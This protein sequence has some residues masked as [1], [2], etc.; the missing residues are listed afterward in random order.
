MKQRPATPCSR[1]AKLQQTNQELQEHIRHLEDMVQGLQKQL[2]A[3][4]KDSSTSSKPPSSDIVKPTKAPADPNAPK[5]SIG[6]QP[7][8]P[9]HFRAPF[10]AEEVTRTLPHRLTQCPDCG[11]LLEETDEPP[12]IVQQIDLNPVTF[13]I[14]EHQSHSGWCPHCHKRFAA[15]LPGRIEHGGLLGPQLTALVAYLKGV[16]H[17]SFST[18]RK[19]FRDVLALPI[20]RSYLAKTISKVSAAL[21]QPYEELWQLLP[22]E[23]CLNVDETGHKLN[24]EHWWTW[25]FRAEL[26]VLY[27]IDANRSADVLMDVLGQEYRGVLGCDCFS[28]YRRYMRECNIIVQFCLAHL[29]R[30]IKFLTKLPRRDEQAYGERL[31]QLVRELFE[32]IHARD[33]L[34]ERVYQQQ[35]QAKKAQI[36]AAGTQAV[37]ASKQCQ[38]MAKRLSKYGDAYF[39]FITTPGIEPTNNLAEQAIRF[40]VIDRHITQGTRSEGGNH[41]SE[42]IWTVLATC[43]LQGQSVYE[44]LCASVQAFWAGTAQPSLLKT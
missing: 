36:V 2:A 6:G 42:R 14:E 24:G 19:F 27:H 8:H 13:T 39:T 44:F 32:I 4:K 11:Q 22:D 23:K 41:W 43:A 3:A 17:A 28:A 29:I 5:R 12:R 33:K 21:A 20:S 26:F 15:P 40:V 10:P 31:R 16:C 38:A 1:C 30:D 35:L 9:A 37:P 18:I 7:G 25:C 34:T